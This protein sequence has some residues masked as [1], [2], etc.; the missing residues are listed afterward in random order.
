M[1][2]PVAFAGTC[3][4]LASLAL[5]NT[6][7]TSAKAVAAGPMSAGRGQASNVPASCQVH[8]IIKPTAVSAIHF[9]VW[10]PEQGW[11][12]SLQVA[13]NGGLAGS[14]S[15]G[16]M[17]AALR[18]G[19]AAASTDTGH[20]SQEP[21][22][23]LED[24]ERVIDY[25]YRGLHLTTEN[26][27]AIVKTFYTQ[28]A[29]CVVLHGVLLR[30]QAGADGGAAL[31]RRF[32]WHCRGRR[33]EF[34]DASNVERSV[35]R[36]RHQFARNELARREIGDRPGRRDSRVRRQRRIGRRHHQRSPALPFRSE[37]TFV[38]GRRYVEVPDGGAGG[39]GGE[40]VQRSDESAHRQESLSRLVSRAAK[41]VGDARAGRW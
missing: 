21:R 14:I 37:E 39:R 8:G 4:S 27:K 31:S 24:R 25:S 34:L 40:A 28:N 23:W 5:P 16:P 30:R 26:A 3:E 29:K 36:R 22:E 2:T 17:A 10:M 11:N 13:G 20:T 1:I 41:W 12:G 32:R 18:N 7:I 35:E 15:T 6:T 33:G 38:H 9:E 19:F